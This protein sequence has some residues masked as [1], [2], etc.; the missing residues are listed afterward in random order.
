MAPAH[1]AAIPKRATRQDSLM[2]VD[3]YS[4]AQSYHDRLGVDIV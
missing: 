4:I 1:N 2:V 3:R